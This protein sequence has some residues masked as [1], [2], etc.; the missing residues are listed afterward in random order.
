MPYE[1]YADERGGDPAFARGYG[2]GGRYGA[3]YEDLDL[4]ES[5]ASISQKNYQVPGLDDDQ[6][7]LRGLAAGTQY[8]QS[9][10]ADPSMGNAALAHALNNYWRQDQA[11]GQMQQASAGQAPSAAAIG[12]RMAMDDA[13]ARQYAAGGAG[14]NQY[15]A[16]QQGVG[17]MGAINAQYG[18]A[19]AGE[20]GQAQQTQA[21]FGAGLRSNALQQ[22]GQSQDWASQQAQLD[23]A[24]MARNDEMAR[25][26]TSQGNQ[27]DLDQLT[28]N[29]A[30]E[31]QKGQSALQI[32]SAQQ[33]ATD[34]ERDRYQR[35][36]AG[37]ANGLAGAATGGVAGGVF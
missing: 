8:R 19:R 36:V 28:A 33:A 10:Q 7:M 16:G 12:S 13:I 24:Q 27:L 32:R 17:A 2:H 30:Y 3:G 34:A 35:R 4:G 26:Y 1:N 20:I 9:V 22:M 11:L 21:G 15:L 14:A 23:A 29:Q 25:Y 37:F 5:P 18:A 6:R 31:A